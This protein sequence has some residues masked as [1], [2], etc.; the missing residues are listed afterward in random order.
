MNT[1]IVATD[2]SKA[3]TNALAYASNL[4]RQI[5]SRIVLCHAYY[6]VVTHLDVP[7]DLPGEEE[8][9]AENMAK[10]TALAQE[11]NRNY[12]VEVE[13]KSGP[14]PVVHFLSTVMADTK[15]DLVVMGM[16]GLSMLDQRLFGSTTVNLIN[17]AKYPVLVVHEHTAYTPMNRIML[18]S[19]L[20][21]NNLKTLDTLA[22]LARSYQAL[23]QIVHV[24]ENKEEEEKF[25]LSS[26]RKLEG[27]FQQIPHEYVS[28]LDKDITQ[29]IE[30][31]ISQYKPDLLVML[32]QEHN[33]WDR[34][35]NKSNTGKMAFKV[36]IP[37]L[38]LPAEE[39]QR[40]YK[41]D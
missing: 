4:A 10:L 40:I 3:A 30:K 31:A 19:D 32:P 41:E 5:G 33:F 2:Y 15:A 35:F 38:A 27:P 20:Q 22:S 21:S 13:C 36:H 11:V 12:G 1:I 29:G 37:L 18:A 14:M 16:K 7:V 39:P 26:Q 25:V 17:E 8:L 34:L 6:M 28:V 9:K 23:V 24:S